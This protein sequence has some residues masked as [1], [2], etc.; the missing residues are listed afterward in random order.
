MSNQNRTDQSVQIPWGAW[1]NETLLNLTF[2]AAWEVDL[3]DI[4]D[5]ERLPDAEIDAVFTEPHSSAPLR[6]L[7]RGKQNVVVA[8]EDITRPARLER[9]LQKILTELTAGGVSRDN[10]TITVCNGAHAPM[11]RAEM[12]RKYGQDVVN[13]HLILNHNPYDNLI[14]T[15][16]VLG[17]TPVRV[18]RNYYEADLKIGIGT[19]MPHSFA[20]FSSGG[21]LILPGLSDIATLERSHKFVMMGFR[22]GVNDVET[23]KF[24]S[25]LEDVVSRIGMDFFVGVVPNSKREIAGVFPGHLVEAHRAGVTFARDIFR[26]TI[27]PVDVVVLNAY[28]KDTELIQ[29]DTAFTPLKTIKEN[30]VREGG[31]VVIVSKCSNGFGHHSLFGPGMRLYRKPIKRKFLQDRELIVFSPNTNQAEFATLFWDG[32]RLANDWETILSILKQR[33]PG[34]CK[35]SVLSCAPMQLL[36]RA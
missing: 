2:P 26:S 33:F 1:Y 6:E 23:N 12:V 24:R 8:V 17:K 13:D 4:A 9:I 28:P 34:Q 18:N 15:G 14:D 31:I 36:T 19:I 25:E 11:P 7:A 10:I 27:Q 20:G 3:C 22:G 30:I 32:Y 16:I 21:K 29:A 35:V 5:S